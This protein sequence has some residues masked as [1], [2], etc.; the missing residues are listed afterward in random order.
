LIAFLDFIIHKILKPSIDLPSTPV[1][2]MRPADSSAD[3]GQVSQQLP[4][5]KQS[6]RVQ[7]HGN[8][9][10]EAERASAEG[11]NDHKY[12]YDSILAESRQSTPRTGDSEERST[13]DTWRERS[14]ASGKSKSLLQ[15]LS[16]SS[17]TTP[18][19]ATSDDQLSTDLGLAS[20]ESISDAS[21]KSR[22]ERHD[23]DWKR[24]SVWV[25]TV[26]MLREVSTQFRD[27]DERYSTSA[28]ETERMELHEKLVK[29]W[30][31][32]YYGWERIG[33]W[34]QNILQD[35]TAVP[36]LRGFDWSQEKREWRRLEQAY[37][38]HLQEHKV[39]QK[40]TIPS[41]PVLLL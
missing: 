36:K 14:G 34:C 6:E 24:H 1:I 17:H 38:R 10:A 28:S 8:Q 11:R 21:A 13:R 4:E 2:I 16:L 7:K 3:K 39:F 25:N 30:E 5:P 18:S 37:E 26:A 19:M 41:L 31:S 29:I 40:R 12:T 20:I 32:A 15:E 23:L 9:L 27:L 22:M 35:D 33:V